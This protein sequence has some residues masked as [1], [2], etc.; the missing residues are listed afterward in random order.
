MTPTAKRETT[1]IRTIA[2]KGYLFGYPLMTIDMT[3]QVGANV[4][5]AG[6]NAAHLNRFGQKR[7]FPDDTFRTVVSPNADTLYSFASLNLLKEPM[8][9]SVPAMGARYYLMPMLDAW[10]N[11]FASPGPPAYSR[12]KLPPTWSGSA[13]SSSI[14]LLGMNRR[15]LKQQY[16]NNAWCGDGFGDGSLS[17]HFRYTR[18]NRFRGLGNDCPLQPH[19]PVQLE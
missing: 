14:R 2:E 3:R 6:Q 11:V 8:V 19:P 15:F 10:T 16:T 9:L 7:E 1:E 4:P 12:S 5:G 17:G 18:H 13:E